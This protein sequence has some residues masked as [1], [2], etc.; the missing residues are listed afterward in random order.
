MHDIWFNGFHGHVNLRFRAP[1]VP[2]PVGERFYGTADIRF[3]QVSRRVAKRLNDLVCGC[4]GCQ[5][6]ERAAREDF[7]KPGVWYVRLPSEGDE[8]RGCYPQD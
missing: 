5:C 1:V 7:N 8:V 6:G 3:A 4:E 2:S